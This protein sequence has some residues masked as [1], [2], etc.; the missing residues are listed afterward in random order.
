MKV[1]HQ[2]PPFLQYLCFS[3]L[4]CKTPCAFCAGCLSLRN[5]LSA[6]FWQTGNILF[7]YNVYQSSRYINLFDNISGQF[8]CNDFF[9]LCNYL[10]LRIIFLDTKR[11]LYV[12][13]DLNG[14]LHGRF[15]RL[16]LIELR[17]CLLIY[18]SLASDNLPHFFCDMRS[19]RIQQND[20]CL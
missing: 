14:N 16:C 4:L 3:F 20:Q 17:P 11:S 1:S 7:H 15:H 18:S 8:I 10:I 12:T 13:I 6:V 19:N 5:L 9:C 2:R